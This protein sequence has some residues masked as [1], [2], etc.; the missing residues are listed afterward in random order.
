MLSGHRSPY[1]S[2]SVIKH[3]TLRSD[4]L[5]LKKNYD[6]II[7]KGDDT[8]LTRQRE[9]FLTYTEWFQSVV[10]EDI[11]LCGTSAL[12]ILQ[13]FVGYRYETEIFAY[14]TRKGKYDNIN[15]NIV[16]SFDKIDYVIINGVKCTTFQQTIND[17][18]ADFDNTDE[19]AL[20]EALCKYYYK[21]GKSYDGLS[22]A[23]SNRSIFERVSTDAIDYYG[24]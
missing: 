18:L 12:E 24:N 21:N 22:I 20:T 16:E 4:G 14:A 9:D 17:M 3:L 13:R 7:L 11:I 19:L 5:I 23:P 15:Y 8:M 1:V 2:I 10:D 6:I